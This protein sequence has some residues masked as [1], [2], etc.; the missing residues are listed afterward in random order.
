M[1]RNRV[2][3]TRARVRTNT[4]KDLERAST[5]KA[6][7]ISSSAGS[8]LGGYVVMN[9]GGSHAVKLSGSISSSAG[10]IFLGPVIA[11]NNLLVS[12]TFT[13]NGS[14][15]TF[16]DAAADV[17]TSTAQFTA[18]QGVTSAGIITGSAAIKGHSLAI[19]N[20]VVI[21]GSSTHHGTL[22]SSYGATFVG[23]IIA[24]SIVLSGALGTPGAISCS[25]EVAG[26]TLAIQN[27][28]IIT[29]SSTHHGTFTSTTALVAQTTLSGAGGISGQSLTAQ[30]NITG[31]A[32]IQGHTLAIQN[33]AI[34]TGSFHHTGAFDVN[35][36]TTCAINNSNTSNG[37]VIGAETDDVPVS[38]GHSGAGAVGITAGAAS[39]WSTSAGALTID[40]AASTLTL[41][42]FQGITLQTGNTAGAMAGGIILDA[43]GSITLDVDGGDGYTPAGAVVV[44]F[45]G[46]P[47]EI[48][49]TTAGSGDGVIRQRVDGKDLI[50]QQFDGSEVARFTD[51][52]KLKFKDD[53]DEWIKGTGADLVLSAGAD[54]TIDSAT[55]KLEWGSNSGEH[56]V[57]DGSNGL[58]MASGAKIIFDATQG[59]DIDSATGDVT[60]MDGGT[61]QLALDMDTTNGEIFFQLKVDSDDLVFKQYDGNEVIRI[62]DDR[63]LYFYDQGGEHISSD[64]T[65]MTIGSGN[66]I[67]LTATTD[68][69]VPADVGLTFGDDGEKI[70]GDGTDLSISSSGNL[71]LTSTVNEAA[72]IY[73]RANAGTSETI[74]I[75]ADQGT[76]VTEGAASVSLLSDAGGV[77]LRSTANLANAINITN[78]GGTTGTIMVF[79]DQGTSVTEGAASIQLLTDAGGVG[80]KSTANLA[81]AILLTADGGTSETIKVHSDQGTGAGSITLLSDAGGVSIDGGSTSHGVKIGTAT[82][83]TPVSIGHTTSETTINDNLTVTGDM[84]V[85]GTTTTVASTVATVVDPLI[86]LGQGNSTVSKD[87]GLVFIRSSNNM[88]MIFDESDDYFKVADIGSE[89]GTTSGNI[90][91]VTPTNMMVGKLAISPVS[92]GS[93]ANYLGLAFSDFMAVAGQDFVVDAARDIILD[94]DGADVMLKDAGTQYLKFTNNSGDA[95]IYNGVADKDI[96]FKD[97]GGNEVFRMDGSAESLLMAST[98]KIEFN[99]SSQF[100]HGSSATVL[101]IG[102]TDEV[103]LTATTFDINADAVIL[104]V[105]AA[106]I[107]ANEQQF[108]S[109]SV[110]AGYNAILWGPIRVVTTMAIGADSNVKIIDFED[111]FKFN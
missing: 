12:G 68:I 93:T 38:I 32:A 80:I 36:T 14:T 22:S 76:S 103:D 31:S 70:E 58:T 88:G 73:L 48:R 33:G 66:D 52:L 108:V 24:G 7:K 99:D 91:S 9:Q 51:D 85:N 56:I 27:G 45:G 40:A 20:G 4:I 81:N 19:Q 94:A 25:A 100:I 10:A 15:V 16:G 2:P 61:A 53:G 111:A 67:N 106:A 83:G 60:F 97:L 69:N 30:E 23:K 41:D 59:I 101:S 54:I 8:T 64:G 107:I 47:G 98:N 26:H 11:N 74:K 75:H 1:A 28:A 49:F 78:D 96:I 43:L 86:V 72:A 13:V 84:T 6:I 3:Y 92:D 79:N 102:A 35:A 37:V 5:L 82:S 71:N 110:P 39:T 77:E 55:S 63:K 44:K 90:S 95:E 29:G 34:I 50:I 57:G 42:G 104:G 65:D 87:L 18:S 21:T 62:A 105:S 17:V 46:A 109:A 89:D